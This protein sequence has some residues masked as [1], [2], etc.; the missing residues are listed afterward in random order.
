MRDEV[1]RHP[2]SRICH[3]DRDRS[4]PR[5]IER[6]T[7][8]GSHSYGDYF[9]R[10]RTDAKGEVE[11]FINAFTVNETYFYREDHQL[12]CL[13]NDLLAARLRAKSRQDAIRI[14]S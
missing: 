5:A 2:V 7:V 6:M 3:Q 12:S 1:S 14:W 10:L 11:Q 4:E 13:T 8:T 9:S